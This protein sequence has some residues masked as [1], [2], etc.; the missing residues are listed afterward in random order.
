MNSYNKQYSGINLTELHPQVLEDFRK[1]YQ[2]FMNC[3][4]E[5][6]F[7]Y[8]VITYKPSAHRSLVYCQN[9]YGKSECYDRIEKDIAEFKKRVIRDLFTNEYS[10]QSLEF[11]FC[12][13]EEPNYHI[14]ILMTKP[15]IELIKNKYREPFASKR[16]FTETKTAVERIARRMSNFG[17]THCRKTFD[18]KRLKEYC[19]K[20][21]FENNNHRCIDFMNSD[22]VKYQIDSPKTHFAI[23]HCA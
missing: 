2:F 5:N 19:T 18:L 1:K 17:F 21:M 3:S 6:Y 7:L 23:R 10:G 14:N 22:L 16:S 12:L 13:E 8:L 15:D 9:K 20:E 4:S 11:L